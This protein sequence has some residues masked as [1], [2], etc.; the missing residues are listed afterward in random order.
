MSARDIP[1]LR[2]EWKPMLPWHFWAFVI[3]YT[4]VIVGGLALLVTPA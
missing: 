4:I 1:K 3:G 2:E